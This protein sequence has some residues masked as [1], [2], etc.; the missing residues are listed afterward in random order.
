MPTKKAEAEAKR[1]PDNQPLNSIQGK[2]LARLSGLPAGEL[3]GRSVAEL[4]DQL[5]WRFN[6]DWFLF[7]QVCGQVVRVDPLTGLKYPVP[8]ATVNFIDTDCDWLWFFPPGWPWGWIFPWGFCEQEVLATT[9]TDGCGNFCVWIPRFDIDW[10]LW[11]RRERICFPWLFRRPSIGDLLQRIEQEGLQRRFP[12]DPNP[13]DPAPL[14]AILE[15]R[16]DLAGT[17]GVGVAAR[18]RASAASRNVGAAS[19]SARNLLAG[20][21]FAQPVPP[22]LHAEVQ[23]LHAVGDRGAIGDHL[24]L[25]ARRAEKLDLSRWYGPFLRCFDVYFPEWFP[26]FEVPDIAIQ[27]TQDTDA[28]GDQEVIY[29]QAFGAPWAIPTP[30][31]ELDAAQFALALPTPGCGPDF[32]CADTPAIQMVGLMPIDPGYVEGTHGFAIRPNPARLSGHESVGLPT[33]PSTAPFEGTLQLYGCVHIGASTHY[34]ILIEYAPSD[35]LAAAP[36]FGSQKPLMEQWHMYHF[37]PFIDQVQQPINSDGWYAILDDTWYPVHLLANWNPGAMGSYRLT[38]EIGT[39]AGG[40]VTIDATAPA[41]ILFVDN[42]VPNTTFTYLQWRYVGDPVFNSL[43]LSCPMITRDPARAIEIQVGVAA[44]APHLRAVAISAGGCGPM[45]TISPSSVDHWHSTELD[46]GWIDNTIYTVPAHSQAGCYSWT[47]V[48]SNR[49][50]NPAG[51]NN[52]LAVD[53]YYDPMEVWITNTISVA[54][55]DA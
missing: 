42:A 46:N 30:N 34:R 47:V 20:A 21:A 41:V 6:P 12:V 50:F 39:L 2:R 11:W 4:A 24:K 23:R 44:S 15:S 54:I 26:V 8:G 13:P 10:I 35:G 14:V 5:R 43:A 55:V 31:L 16:P 17:I 32:P 49:A 29:D 1:R 18:L 22:P 9:T 28:D 45:A 3:T 40:V 52:G 27:V 48:A 33:Y 37:T 36:T 53:W 25:D 38:L 51:D 19:I 7:E